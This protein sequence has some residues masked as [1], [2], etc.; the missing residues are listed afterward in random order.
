MSDSTA[1]IVA[2]KGVVVAESPP[3]FIDAEM[4]RT[5][6]TYLQNM[7]VVGIRNFGGTWSTHVGVFV[8]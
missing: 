4:P 6:T 8:A 5:R 1:L 3:A 7:C 2:L